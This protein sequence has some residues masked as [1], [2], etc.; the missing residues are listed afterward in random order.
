MAVDKIPSAGIESGGVGISNLSATGTP[1]STTFLR[2][3]NT[4]DAPTAQGVGINQTWQ[5]PTRALNTNYTNT[6]G[7]P[8]MIAMNIVNGS[9]QNTGARITVDGVALGVSG[10]VNGQAGGAYGWT[11]AIVPNG[12]VYSATTVSAGSLATW[13][14]LR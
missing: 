11:C 3:D 14:E 5:S 2:G 13:V 10:D 9:V 8:I 6:T 4:W 12:S 7:K 1:S